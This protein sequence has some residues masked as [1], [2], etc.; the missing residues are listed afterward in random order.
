MK[1]EKPFFRQLVGKAGGVSAGVETGVGDE[2]VVGGQRPEWH[3]SLLRLG[4]SGS[5][6]RRRRETSSLERLAMSM[7][8]LG[9]PT[10]AESK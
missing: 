1:Q 7:N 6:L 9:R 10:N 4:E 8:F 2:N 3:A 5:M